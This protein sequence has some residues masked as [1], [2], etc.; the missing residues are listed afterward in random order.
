MPKVSFGGDARPGFNREDV[1]NTS[2]IF[3]S[4]GWELHM[5]SGYALGYTEAKSFAKSLLDRVQREAWQREVCSCQEVSPKLCRK[6]HSAFCVRGEVPKES[7][8]SVGNR[9]GCTAIILCGVRMKVPEKVF[10][11]AF[12]QVSLSVITALMNSF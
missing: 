7:E 9:C 4:G 10:A 11:H 5:G 3:A 1:R 6:S 2:T 8:S 12:V